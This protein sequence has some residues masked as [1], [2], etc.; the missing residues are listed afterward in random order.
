LKALVTQFNFAAE[1][2]KVSSRNILK[3][4]IIEKVLAGVI[5][6]GIYLQEQKG[7]FK[8]RGN[9]EHTARHISE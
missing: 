4:N 7:L 6:Y 2:L 3:G 1:R 5:I 8:K 9:R